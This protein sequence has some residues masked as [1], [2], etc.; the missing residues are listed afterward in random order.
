MSTTFSQLMRTAKRAAGQAI[1]DVSADWMQGRSV[2]GGLQVAIA[3][4]AMRTC[5]PKAPLRTLQATFIAPV[6]EGP[7]QARARVIRQGKSA[8]HVEARIEGEKEALAI[9]VGVFGSPRPSKA[10]RVPVLPHL[11]TSKGLEL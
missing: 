1:F 9:V 11:D 3:L 6:P 7:V 8:T 5:A 2:F 4:E 10:E